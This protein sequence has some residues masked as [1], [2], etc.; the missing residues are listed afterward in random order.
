MKWISVDDRLPDVDEFLGANFRGNAFV[1]FCWKYKVHNPN[2]DFY[3]YT[4][5]SVIHK[6]NITHWMPLPEPPK[7]K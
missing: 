7:V 2:G 6:N 1:A 5:G 3:K 4:G